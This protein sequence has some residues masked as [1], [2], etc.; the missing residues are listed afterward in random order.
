MG[1]NDTLNGMRRSNTDRIVFGIC[2][3]L[4]QATGTPVW[5]WRAAFVLLA[6]FG[7]A[8]VVTYLVLWIFMP[9]PPPA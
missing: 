4:A 8:G 5:I 6:I 2:G 3:G 9:P 1:F 7:G